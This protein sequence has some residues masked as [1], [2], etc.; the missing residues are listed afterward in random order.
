MKQREP[1]FFDATQ[2]G[3]TAVT[4]KYFFLSP[5]RHHHIHTRQKHKTNKNAPTKR[6]GMTPPTSC[7][8]RVSFSNLIILISSAPSPIYGNQNE[9]AIQLL[10]RA[11]APNHFSLTQRTRGNNMK[12]RKC[13]THHHHHHHHHT[14]QQKNKKTKRQIKSCL[15][16]KKVSGSPYI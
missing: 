14:P 2:Q 11:T 12:K 15:R 3:Y 4:I 9:S 6:K 1:S 16:R 13:P 8:V 5:T 10:Q 7:C